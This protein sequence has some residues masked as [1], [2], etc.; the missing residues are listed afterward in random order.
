MS[1]DNGETA[2]CPL[3]S[4]DLPLSL[5]FSHAASLD[6][7]RCAVPLH[8][9]CTKRLHVLHSLCKVVFYASMF[10]APGMPSFSTALWWGLRQLTRMPRMFHIGKQV[11]RGATLYWLPGLT[12]PALC[13]H[14]HPVPMGTGQAGNV[15]AIDAIEVRKFGCQIPLLV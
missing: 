2:T 13:K 14:W 7:V 3:L 15:F 12:D 9:N 11:A 8:G 5:A 4:P 1:A 10:R 6:S